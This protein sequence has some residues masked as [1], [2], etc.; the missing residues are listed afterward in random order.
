MVLFVRVS[1]TSDFHL[2]DLSPSPHYSPLQ[3]LKFG[4]CNIPRLTGL[5]TVLIPVLLIT[6]HLNGTWSS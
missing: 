4:Q 6:I 2:N 5:N 3:L 1:S